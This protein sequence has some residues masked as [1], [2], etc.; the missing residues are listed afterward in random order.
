MRGSAARRRASG[1]HLFSFRHSGRDSDLELLPEIYLYGS[2]FNSRDSG[3][4][5]GVMPRMLRND[6]YRQGGYRSARESG[7]H[8]IAEQFQRA[9]DLIAR[10]QSLRDQ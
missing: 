9:D 1:S 2:E 8:L 5:S 3:Y 4:N 7:H 10:V 6:D